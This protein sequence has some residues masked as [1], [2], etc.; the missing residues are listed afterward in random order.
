MSSCRLP[1]WYSKG[2]DLLRGFNEFGFARVNN[3]HVCLPTRLPLGVKVVT[4]RNVSPR[5][6]HSRSSEGADNATIHPIRARIVRLIAP[7]AYNTPH[8]RHAP[9]PLVSI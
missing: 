1:T 2:F 6:Q 4:H 8:G 9:L 3:R 5:G 7:R